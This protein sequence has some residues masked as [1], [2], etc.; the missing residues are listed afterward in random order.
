MFCKTAQMWILGSCDCLVTIGF[1]LATN[2]PAFELLCEL[3]IADLRIDNQT[4]AFP[5]LAA[6]I[7]KSPM[8][9]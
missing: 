8:W 3:P 5:P 1:G 4:V 2:D 7:R 9:T 6:E